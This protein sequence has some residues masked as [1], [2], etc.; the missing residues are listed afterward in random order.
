MDIGGGCTEE[1]GETLDI[2]GLGVRDAV[3]IGGVGVQ[4]A[5]D[6]G[7]G[8]TEECGG[9][10]VRGKG[11]AKSPFVAV[12]DLGNAASVV[13][14]CGPHVSESRETC[15]RVTC[16]DAGGARDDDRNEVSVERDGDREWSKFSCGPMHQLSRLPFA[17]NDD[18]EP[19]RS[20]LETGRWPGHKMMFQHC[21]ELK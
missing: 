7:G 14:W 11:P 1:H 18:R 9:L 15:L 17:S 2:G 8:C 19:L 4:D 12:F 20:L 3:D 16:G 10:G 21:S 13:D 6:I 5:V